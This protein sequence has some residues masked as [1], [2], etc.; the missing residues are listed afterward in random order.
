MAITATPIQD[1]EHWPEQFEL[2]KHGALAE[3]HYL[4]DTDNYALAVTANGLPPID[5]PYS[6][7]LPDLRVIGYRPVW[8]TFKRGADATSTGRCVLRV[9]YET[10]G[11][12][13]RLNIEAGRKWTEI[14]SATETITAKA[15]TDADPRTIAGG[16]GV[17]KDLGFC[18]LRIRTFHPTG[19][20]LPIGQLLD[21]MDGTINDGPV[22]TPPLFGAAS[23]LSF[24]KG[25]LHYRSVEVDWRPGEVLEVTH[26]VGMRRDWDAVWEVEDHEGQIVRIDRG[27]IYREADYG[28]LW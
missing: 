5:T 1:D 13:G 11:L 27:P 28:G 15:T 23:G 21:V 9:R 17:G 20:A 26:I 25:Q 24:A 3:T 4:I 12:T 2:L 22:S 14:V 18:D 8:R 10:P 6:A 19:Y 7:A 16:D